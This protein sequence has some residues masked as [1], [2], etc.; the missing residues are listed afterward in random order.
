M[1]GQEGQHGGMKT[2]RHFQVRHVA[3]TVELHQLRARYALMRGAAQ[4]REVAQRLD[5]LGR[6]E[7]A[8]EYRAVQWANGQQHGQPS[9]AAPS[10][11]APA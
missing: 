3:S 7:V 6:R 1:F 9:I 10:G 8:A 5:E 4:S 11:C 2:I